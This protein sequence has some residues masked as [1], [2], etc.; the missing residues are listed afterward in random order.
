L[1]TSDKERAVP[2]STPAELIESYLAAFRRVNPEAPLPVIEYS[3][4]WYRYSFGF[5]RRN[6]RA[7]ELTAMRDTLLKRAE[8]HEKSE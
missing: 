2:K 5:L 1:A 8:N 6:I 4:G 7:A 3:Q